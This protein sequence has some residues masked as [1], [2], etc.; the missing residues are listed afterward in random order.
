MHTNRYSSKIDTSVNQLMREK[1][2]I[3]VGRIHAA[4]NEANLSDEK[5]YIHINTIQG[6]R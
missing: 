6:L 1:K 2:A 4:I 3:S 5:S